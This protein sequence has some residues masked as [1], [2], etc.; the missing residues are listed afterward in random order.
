MGPG[1]AGGG[2]GRLRRRA[3]PPRAA[4]RPRDLDLEP[5]EPRRDDRQ[6]L[7]RG[8]L[9]R[10]RQDGGERPRRH[11]GAARRELRAARLAELGGHPAPG[12]GERDARP[13]AARAAGAP[14]RVLGGHPGAVPAHPPAGLR[15]QPRRA[16]RPR[17]GEPGAPRRRLRGDARDRGGGAGEALPAAARGRARRPALRRDA[18]GARGGGDGARAASDLRRTRGPDGH[19]ARP[20][21]ARVLAAPPLHRGRARG[22]HP[23]RVRRPQPGGG[24]LQAGRPRTPPRKPWPPPPPRARPR[25]TEE[26]LGGAEGRAPAPPQ[27]PRRQETHRLRRGHRGRAVPPAG[28][29][30]R[31]RGHPRRPRHR[32]EL[33]RPRRRRLPPHPAA[34]QPEGPRRD[35]QDGHPRPGDLRAGA[36]L[37]GRDERRARRRPRAQPLQREGLRAAGLRRVQAPQGGVRPGRHHE[38]G[39]GGGRAGR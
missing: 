2:A 5:R 6:Q 21:V 22:A 34:D 24:D 37:R 31:V 13:A 32:G 20:R 26:R 3:R 8:P 7:G 35:P 16:A 25:R 18:P 10:L 39:E 9:A 28:V 14:G 19:G 17:G 1:A 23:G 33:L 15:L 29:H 12:A 36:R 4:V 38:P 11:R 27:P 30:P